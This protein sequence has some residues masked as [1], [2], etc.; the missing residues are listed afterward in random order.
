MIR[1]EI[2]LRS[3]GYQ[4][5]NIRGINFP[6]YSFYILTILTNNTKTYIMKATSL[7]H[8]EASVTPCSIYGCLEY[9]YQ[10]KLNT[11]SSSWVA[12][13]YGDRGNNNINISL[14]NRS[15]KQFS[16]CY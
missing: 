11:D 4:S 9:F 10:H 3:S 7:T 14:G 8:L 5:S 15:N 6:L 2:Q 1:Q 13:Q 16:N 12:R